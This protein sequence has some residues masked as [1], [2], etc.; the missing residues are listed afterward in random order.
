MLANAY[1][2]L[3]VEVARLCAVGGL[4]PHVRVLPVSSGVFAGRLRD[5]IAML[6]ILAM[7]YAWR[8][9]PLNDREVLIRQKISLCCGSAQSYKEHLEAFMAARRFVIQGRGPTLGVSPDTRSITAEDAA[10]SPGTENLGTHE[11]AAVMAALVRPRVTGSGEGGV[12]VA[13]RGDE[14]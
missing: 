5:N 10:L 1:F 7:G 6:G 14:A 12:P 13:A 4:G 3:F 2:H 8:R 9:L 11:L